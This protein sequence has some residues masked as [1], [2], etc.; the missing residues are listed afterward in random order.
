MYLSFFFKK[1]LLQYL[2]CQYLKYK[3]YK[4]KNNQSTIN[5]EVSIVPRDVMC[6][7]TYH[8]CT[9]LYKVCRS[10]INEQVLNI[11]SVVIQTIEGANLVSTDTWVAAAESLDISVLYCFLLPWHLAFNGALKD[12]YLGWL[13]FVYNVS[14][15]CLSS[16]RF[17][18]MSSQCLFCWRK[19]PTDRVAGDTQLW[20]TN[21]D[22]C[23]LRSKLVQ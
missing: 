18:M 4:N 15:L 3:Q 17:V 22:H 7:C 2:T 1:N 21:I 16:L 11:Y 9:H 14:A 10:I 23:W 20:V 13:P 19:R 8:L 6:K 12:L 5:K